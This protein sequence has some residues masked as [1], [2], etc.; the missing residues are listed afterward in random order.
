MAQTLTRVLLHVVFSTKNRDPL[1]VPE[2]ESEL[3]AYMGGICRMLG[4]PS[5][6]IGGTAD[7]VHLLVVMSRTL[8]IADLLM[9]VKK[10]S[11]K[12]A[13]RRGPFAWQEGYGAFSVGESGR[14]AAIRYIEGQKEH[15]SRVSF[16]D[17]LLTLLKR[18]NVNYDPRYIWS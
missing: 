10:D 3:H 2:R 15:H 18:Y 12:W 17:E 4:A 14:A 11:S 7:H 16:Q 13:G 8:T 9:H 1:I 6:A 5:L